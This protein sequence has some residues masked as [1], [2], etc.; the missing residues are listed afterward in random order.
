M[1]YNK[2][3]QLYMYMYLSSFIFFPHKDYYRILGRVLCCYTA[4]PKWPIIP[5]TTVCI[6]QSQVPSPSFLPPSPVPF[7]THKFFK[8]CGSVFVLQISSFVSFF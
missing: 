7:G 8:V 4:G 1:L 6:C 3:I 2:V 5:Y